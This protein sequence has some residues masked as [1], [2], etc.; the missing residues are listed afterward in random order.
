MQV[1]E[2]HLKHLAAVVRTGSMTDGAA[3]LGLSQPALSRSISELEKRIGAPVLK[4]GRRPLEPTALGR[5]L[6]AQG[7][8]ILSA[9]R[10]ASDIVEGFRGGLAG[11]VRIG[12]VP[13]FVDALI[14][15][16]IAE[17]RELS[18]DTRV[19]LS[20]GYLPE[21]KAA[22]AADQIDMAIVPIAET[23]NLDEF[24]FESFLSARN[25]VACRTNHPLL[26]KRGLT[27]NDLMDYP[28]IEPPAGS[29]LL[30]DMNAVLLSFGLTDA[31]VS[32][33]GG[34][35]FSVLN[36]LRETDALTILPHTVI[37]ANRH[38]CRV[39]V[40]PVRIA[41]GD[42]SLGILRKAGGTPLPATDRFTQFVSKRFSD[43]QLAI[44]KHENAIAWRR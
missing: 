34:S 32:F 18:P 14:S 44:A 28:W 3:L 22:L 40:L 31:E 33:S 27:A 6:A 10:T 39:T 37:F 29:P 5:Q 36:Y 9:N 38:E 15:N 21:M 2:R 25:V 41:R 24:A 43:L 1:T 17:F 16:M 20:Y 26:R 13:F 42:R 35:L 30:G 4:P 23:Q 19:D 8:I 12:G 7:M 11:L